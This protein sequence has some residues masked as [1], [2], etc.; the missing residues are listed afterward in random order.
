MTKTTI[1]AVEMTRAIREQH[2]LVLQKATTAERIAFYREK[3]R[4][5]QTV[6]T[7]PPATSSVPH[8]KAS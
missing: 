1:K 2:A 5:M 8:Q 6:A 4:K 3:A 7:E